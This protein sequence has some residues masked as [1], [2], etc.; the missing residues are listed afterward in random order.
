M[1][2]KN[3]NSN[4]DK[5]VKT[6]QNYKDNGQF[7][8]FLKVASEGAVTVVGFKLFHNVIVCGKMNKNM[9]WYVQK[10]E[11]ALKTKGEIYDDYKMYPEQRHYY[12]NSTGCV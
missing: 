11:N 3:S 4:Y 5:Q 2:P 7:K 8:L 9:S 6:K 10:G 1:I 12:Q